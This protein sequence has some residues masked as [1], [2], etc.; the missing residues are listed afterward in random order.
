MAMPAAGLGLKAQHHADALSDPAAGLWFEV[1]PEN[2]MCAGGP[3]HDQLAA[4]RDKRPVSLHGV[5]LSLAGDERPDRAHLVA[6]RGLV[7]RYEP[8]LVSEHLAWSRRGGTWRPDLL[9]FPRTEAALRRIADHIDETQT[10]L[11]RRVLIENSSLYLALRGHDYPE[12]DFLVALCQRTGCGLLLDVNNV[13]VSANNLD[14]DAEAYLDAVPAGLVGEIHIAGHA[15]DAK[16]GER[17]LID[18]HGAAVSDCVWQH[19]ARLVARIGARPTLIER[20]D[21]IPDYATLSAE[22]DRA[23][24]I[25]A[26][27]VC[28]VAA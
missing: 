7:D 16:L 1:H 17:L 20:D 25:L 9:P 19:Y 18:T 8:F 15:P 4:I 11:G 24:A 22:R 21:N 3:R 12:V 2:Y 26:G 28:D 23:A 14:F 13:V 27:E 10:A 5:G 6:L